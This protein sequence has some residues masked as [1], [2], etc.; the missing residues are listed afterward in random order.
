FAT[1][2]SIGAYTIQAVPDH[3]PLYSQVFIVRGSLVAGFAVPW[4]LMG[5]MFAH[6]TYLLLN[7]HSDKGEIEREWLGRASG[8]HFIAILG[9]IMLTAIV[10]LGPAIY[11]NFPQTVKLATVVSGAVT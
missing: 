9:W 2:V 1:L 7:S 5:T 6:F 10:L 3:I 4:F 8:W 11:Y